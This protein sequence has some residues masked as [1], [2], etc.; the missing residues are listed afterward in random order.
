MS[1]IRHELKPFLGKEITISG[2]VLQYI[3][4]SEKSSL[5]KI[6][7]GSAYVC[8]TEVRLH[9][10]WFTPKKTKP[11]RGD[12][13]EITGVV[14]QYPSIDCNGNRICKYGFSKIKN[15]KVVLRKEEIHT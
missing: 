14:G 4:H 6:L 1:E 13:I 10:L 5:P 12:V 11:R 15:S 7:V 8:G 9:H 2:T 3:P